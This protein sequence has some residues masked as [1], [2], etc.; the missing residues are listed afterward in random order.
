M[1]Y[2]RKR[3]FCAKFIKK[4]KRSF[5]NNLN[6]NKIIDNKSFWKT[7]K[8]SF[9]EKTLKGEKIVLAE[10]DTTFSEK[11]EVAEI[12]WSYFDCI[13]D[14]LNIKRCEVSKEYGDAILNAIKTFEKHPN[15]LIIQELNSSCGFSLESVSLGDVKK[16][17]REQ[18]TEFTTYLI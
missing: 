4:T 16:V 7:V 14:G 1:A 10:N 8:P 17:T 13:V 5:Y 12:F 15:I 9:P 6:V 11:N 3:N 18:I 2:K